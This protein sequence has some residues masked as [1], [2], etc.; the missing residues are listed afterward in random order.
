MQPCVFIPKKEIDKSLEGKSVQG[1][2]FLEPLKS[3]TTDKIPFNILEDYE[4]HE[5]EPEI[6]VNEADLWQCLEGEVKFLCGGELVDPSFRKNPDGTDNKNEIKGEDIR[7]AATHIL[8]PGDWLWI[9]AGQPHKHTGTGKLV[10]IK[11]PKK[12]L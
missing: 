5:N 8:K 12:T 3:I 1:K 11:I 2:T 4:L 9:P 6:H 10:I 7:D